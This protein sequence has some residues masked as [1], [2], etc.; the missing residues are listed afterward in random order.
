MKY[1]GPKSKKCISYAYHVSLK[2][3]ISV[4]YFIIIAFVK[5]MLPSEGGRA[6]FPAKLSNLILPICSTARRHRAFDPPQN[7]L[8]GMF[9]QCRKGKMRFRS[10]AGEVA[11]PPSP[12]PMAVTQRSMLH[13]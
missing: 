3:A 12:S 9:F 13:S 2:I 8:P 11:S 6:T 4:S 5:G 1:F 7:N 10:C